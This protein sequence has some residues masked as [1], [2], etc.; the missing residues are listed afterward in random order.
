MYSPS[1][2][3]GLRFDGLG[4][5]SR[6]A[7]LPGRVRAPE[8][9]P[10]TGRDFLHVHVEIMPYGQ[11]CDSPLDPCTPLR[12]PS[13]RTSHAPDAHLSRSNAGGLTTLSYVAVYV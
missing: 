8:A 3:E 9:E 4:D 7:A 2:S 11:V 13:K 1:P 10:F 6:G 12:M 5:A